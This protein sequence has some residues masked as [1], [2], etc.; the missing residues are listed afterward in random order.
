M[1]CAIA[2]KVIFVDADACRWQF[3]QRQFCQRHGFAAI[4]LI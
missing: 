4:A 3:C 1:E 2:I